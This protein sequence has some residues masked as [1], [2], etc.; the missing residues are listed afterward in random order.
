MQ[1]Q[2][3]ITITDKA[4]KKVKEFLANEETKAAGL[5]VYVA[6]GGCSGL[7][8]GMALEEAPSEEDIVIEES[9]M[10]VF[11]D[12]AS[13]KYMKGSSIDYIETLEASG[14]K[15]NNPNVVSTCACG[16]SFQA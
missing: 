3:L 13:A 15:I 8:Y 7:T 10:K 9:G 11:L 6:G 16:H 14:F 5:R 2:K 12:P 1:Q 4:V